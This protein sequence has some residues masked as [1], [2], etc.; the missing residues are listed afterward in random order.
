M[1]LQRCEVAGAVRQAAG[2][3]SWLAHGCTA[4]LPLPALPAPQMERM[5]EMSDDVW[6][7]SGVV[8]LEELDM[9]EPS[10]FQ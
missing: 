9:E 5:D 4:G 1:R 3:H 8:Q 6:E 10:D 7:G 2:Q